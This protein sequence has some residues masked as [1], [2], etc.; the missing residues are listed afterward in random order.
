MG[1]I[2]AEISSVS[3]LIQNKQLN[4]PHFQR[5]YKW[6]VKN[7]IQLLEDIDRFKKQVSYRIGTI[8]L[9]RDTLGDHIVDGQ[10]RTITF[11]LIIRALSQLEASPMLSVKLFADIQFVA[12]NMFQPK[13]RHPVSKS[14]IQENYREISRRVAHF[15]N[16][17]IEFFLNRC[18]VTYIVIDDIS[19][20]FQFFDSQN[21]RGKD[22]EPHDLLKAFHLREL[23]STSKVLSESAV[24]DLVDTWEEMDTRVLASLFADFLYRVRGWSKGDSSRYFSKKDV[25]LFKG[26][27]LDKIKKYPHVEIYRLVDQY[28]NGAVNGTEKKSFPFQLDQTIINGEYFFKMISHYKGVF[29]EIKNRFVALEPVAKLIVETLDHYGGRNRTGDLYIRMVFNCAL[30]YYTDKFG[31]ENISNAIEKLF[32][33]AYTP[34]LS[35]QSLQFASVDNYVVREY[36]VFKM[37]KEAIFSEDIIRMELPGVIKGQN[38]E[39]TVEIKE[40][41]IKMK[42]YEN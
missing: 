1:I 23:E 37:I 32:I 2:K 11:L 13:F 40:L 24:S 8:V 31:F 10:Q 28:L 21:S 9:H 18:E 27:N 25:S 41:F 36:N 6:S 16:D 26:I 38:S 29:D 14:N 15:D 17:F 12:E 19:E 3:A 42:Y 33:W 34:R 4:I 35:Y 20:A 22:L 5:P 30:L 7:V 39:K